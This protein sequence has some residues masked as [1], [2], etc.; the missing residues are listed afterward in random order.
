MK[1]KVSEW[2]RLVDEEFEGYYSGDVKKIKAFIQQTLDQQKAE[3]VE[4]VR[5]QERKM[6]ASKWLHGMGLS[7][8]QAEFIEANVVASL[9]DIIKRLGGE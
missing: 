9:D 5:E 6:K 1:P 3:I 4:M 2:E 8:S 7:G